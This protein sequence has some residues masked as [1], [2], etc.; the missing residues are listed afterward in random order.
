MD[1]NDHFCKY[2]NTYPAGVHTLGLNAQVVVMD[3]VGNIFLAD[4]DEL[5]RLAGL[6]DDLNSIVNIPR[7]FVVDGDDLVVLLD[8]VLLSLTLRHHPGHKYPSLLLLV[9][10]QPP[11]YEGQT[12][13][14]GAAVHLDNSGTH[15]QRH[16]YSQSVTR[17]N[18]TLKW[19]IFRYE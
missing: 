3:N 4:N 18:L 1:R 5:D 17:R 8:S 11:I 6:L 7:C 13:P 19:K 16:R 9:L 15:R 12:E 10:V 2:N 14:S